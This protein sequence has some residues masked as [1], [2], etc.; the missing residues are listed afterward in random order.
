MVHLV[1]LQEYM[2]DVLACAEL[3][4]I[5][6]IASRVCLKLWPSDA[7]RNKVL[8]LCEISF[9]VVCCNMASPYVL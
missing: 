8:W 4:I 5:S 2:D 7:K 3:I 9:N 1:P 6:S